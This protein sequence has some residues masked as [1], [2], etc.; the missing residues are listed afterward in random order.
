MGRTRGI[1]VLL[2]ASLL[3]TGVALVAESAKVTL[4]G[5][6]FS[7]TLGERGKT[8]G[9][10]D[11]YIF[12]DGAFRSTACDAYGFSAAA[13]AAKAEG[14]A[15]AFE[16]TSHSAKEGEMAWKGTVKGDAIAGTVVWK[17]AG[18][19]PKDYWFKGA[20]QKQ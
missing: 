15:I 6:T 14:T 13:Y 18:K 10:K 20:L 7:G 16:S 3:L 19:A 8:K 1:V 2:G 12:K 11:D 9:D 4:D 5:K 17:K